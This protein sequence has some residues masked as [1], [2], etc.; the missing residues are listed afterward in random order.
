MRE[1]RPSGLEGGAAQSNAPFLPLYMN[2]AFGPAIRRQTEA[3]KM[4]E[5]RGWLCGTLSCEIGRLNQCV[6]LLFLPNGTRLASSNKDHGEAATPIP[7]RSSVSVN[8][9]SR[10]REPGT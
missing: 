6:A 3:G 4:P 2:R 1:I 9:C 5:P 7:T 8:V 10:P